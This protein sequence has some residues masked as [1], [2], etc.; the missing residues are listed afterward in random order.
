MIGPGPE[1]KGGISS[2]VQVYE[3][4]QFFADGSVRML[5]SFKHGSFLNKFKD[6]ASAVFK[7]GWLLLRG[8]GTVLHVH[9]ASRASFWRKSIFIWLAYFARR[10][11]IFHLHAGGFISFIETLSPFKR[12]IAIATINRCDQILCLTSS[13]QIWFEHL[14]PT[15]PVQWWPNPVPNDL[16][17]LNT[18]GN[19]REP[20]VLYLGALLP[21]KG[22]SE[23]LDAFTVL[24]AL[25][26]TAF[27]VLG[28]SGPDQDKLQKMVQDRGLKDCVQF[29]GWI[30]S[31]EKKFWLRR[32]RVV[33][34]ASY[35]EAQPMT[36]LE[37][38]ASGAAVVST[39]V[40]G[41]PDLI[42]NGVQGLLVPPHN[43][44]AFA[45]ALTLVWR[46]TTLRERMV[47]AAYEIVSQRHKATEVCHS[48]HKL[49][50]NLS[51]RKKH[52]HIT[53]ALR[54]RLVDFVR[55]SD[56]IGLLDK[57]HDWQYHTS[58]QLRRYSRVELEKYLAELRS[59]LPMYKNIERYSELPV[60]D[61]RFIRDH[62]CELMNPLYK[63]KIIRKKTGGSTGEPLIYYTGTDSHSYLWAGIYMSWQVAGYQFGDRVAFLAGSSLFATGSR[64]S[65]YYRLLNVT[66]MSSFNMSTESMTEYGT[67]LQRGGF[68]LLYG[69]SAAIHR[70]ARFYLDAGKTL[71]STLRAVV[72]T[73]E[74]LTATMRKDIEAAFGV[75]CY[76]QYGCHD[77]GISSFE[78][79]E[80]NGFHLISMR[81]YHEVLP[82]GELV[83]TDLSNRAMFMPRYN[84]GDIVRM[85]NRVCPCGRGLPLIEEVVGRQN[86]I[87]IDVKGNAVHS[88]F[89]T[90]MFR[91]DE[92]IYSF[93]VTFNTNQLNVNLH[94]NPVSNHEQ[95]ALDTYIRDR[96]NPVLE[97]QEVNIFFNQPFK[98]LANG[99]HRFVMKESN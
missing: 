50:Q 35:I 53:F 12:K 89:F 52:A 25:D 39:N 56:S 91:E 23:L 79:E 8:K 60:I 54:Y 45:Q 70:L 34:L 51:R 5:S 7:Y 82:N 18:P 94:L 72:C 71:D 33:A 17:E 74:T 44:N 69:F 43:A 20:I 55:G 59:A 24:H 15:V 81:C 98:S 3:Q 75:P 86:D 6:A 95:S 93:Q 88:E 46:D 11:I 78:C 49:Y 92:R 30:D 65:I 14:T 66:L 19:V 4:T 36:L 57:L 85:S 16:F 42:E 47:I 32:A 68:R 1:G 87:V 9:V 83:S 48:L 26:P 99:K 61:K 22:I 13:M 41:I 90:H 67:R 10:R 73:S 96:I 31:E 97:F 27:L 63:G 2:V 76:S 21:A 62:Y 40:G 77:A 38:M 37:A 29:L 64:Q 84:T 28:G 80:R 58:E